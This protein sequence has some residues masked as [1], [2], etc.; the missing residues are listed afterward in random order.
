MLAGRVPSGQ[1]SRSVRIRHDAMLMWRRD[2][3][4]QRRMGADV[5]NIGHRA[6]P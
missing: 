2:H 3:G 1:A 6:E 4:L 5:E